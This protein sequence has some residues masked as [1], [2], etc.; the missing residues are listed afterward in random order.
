MIASPLQPCLSPAVAQHT[1]FSSAAGSSSPLAQPTV[2]TYM[3]TGNVRGRES[4][5]WRL[6]TFVLPILFHVCKQAP[7]PGPT[8]C[9][10]LQFVEGTSCLLA[11][12]PEVV[13]PGKEKDIQ[14]IE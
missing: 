5:H 7:S 3:K 4:V 13:L 9:V 12:Q 14:V 8:G 10:A 2:H 1:A 6:I 11:H